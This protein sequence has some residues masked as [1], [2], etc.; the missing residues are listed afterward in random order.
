MG[1]PRKIKEDEVI[2]EEVETVEETVDEVIAAP[3]DVDDFITITASFK[4]RSIDG[5]RISHKY[6]GEGVTVE[7][8]LDTVVGS[9]EDITDEYGKPFPAGLNMLVNATVR[10]SKG[11]EFS[12][13]LAPQDAREIFEAKNAGM[14]KHLFGLGK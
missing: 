14:V 8:A 6:K 4:T 12:R 2:G 7:N 11:Y 9:E 13:A 5:D 1:R 10:T 3:K